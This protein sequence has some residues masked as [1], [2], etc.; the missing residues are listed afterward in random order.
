MK[1]LAKD[2]KTEYLSLAYAFVI[3]CLVVLVSFIVKGI[4]PFGGRTLCSMDGFSQYYPMLMNMTEALKDGEI[5]YS[6][7][8][9]LGFN[10]W[11]QSAYYTNS[12]LC[13]LFIW[14]LTSG[15]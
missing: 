11:A 6:F 7:N 9:A 4:E 10:L 2:K 8:G 15:R 13:F 1:T 3:P 14:C 5:F 12:P